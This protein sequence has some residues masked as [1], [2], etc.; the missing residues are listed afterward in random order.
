MIAELKTDSEYRVAAEPHTPM[1]QR[2]ME[3]RPSR[4]LPILLAL[5][6]VAVIC[7]FFLQWRSRNTAVAFPTPYQ[8]VLLSNGAVYYGQLE[9]YG[10]ANPVLN[11]VF[12]ILGRTDPN[13]KAVSNVLVKRGKELHQPDRM[14]LSPSSIVFVETVGKDSKV[15]QLISEAG[16]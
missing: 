7:G 15:A 16:N 8:A 6:T 3:A 13:T 1:Q 4:A 11:H 9:G 14:Y 10:T 5:L 2:T 12:Y